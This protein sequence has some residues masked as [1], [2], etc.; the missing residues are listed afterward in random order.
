MKLREA[1]ERATQCESVSEELDAFQFLRKHMDTYTVALR[2][3]GGRKAILEEAHELHRRAADVSWKQATEKDT[4]VAAA[5]RRE[6]RGYLIEAIE[7][8]ASAIPSADA[9]SQ[10][11]KELHQ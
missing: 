11:I 7:L 2:A 10:R 9:Y 5:M 4:E 6:S 1:L 8:M 3:L